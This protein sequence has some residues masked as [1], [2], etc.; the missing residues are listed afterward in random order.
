MDIF[1]KI[2]YHPLQH[3]KCLILTI[4]FLYLW[5]LNF[6]KSHQ[7]QPAMSPWTSNNKNIEELWKTWTL[8]CPFNTCVREVLELICA[9]HHRN[10]QSKCENRNKW[11][12][13]DANT[14][15]L[16]RGFQIWSQNW[17]KKNIWP[18]FD[19]KKLEKWQNTQNG[20]FSTLF[21]PRR[22]SNVILCEFWGQLWNTLIILHPLHPPLA[23]IFIFSSS[24]LPCIIWL[25]G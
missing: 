20:L 12:P 14:D 2:Q 18:L 19:K 22:T 4:L 6:L 25:H 17:N 21:W 5:Y 9:W 3:K 13:S 8:L 24:D 10:K 7:I 1:V 15:H 23:M 11:G 16:M